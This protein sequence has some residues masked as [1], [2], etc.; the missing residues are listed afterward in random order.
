MK[1]IIA[2]TAK[3]EELRSRSQT[4]IPT[5][6][7]KA[8]EDAGGIPVIVPIIN[9]SANVI[10][11]AQFADGFL[12]S[13]GDD[14]RPEY[15]G[16]EPLLNLEISPDERTDFEIALFREVLRLQKPV[17]GICLGAQL[18][19]V[20]LGG[21]L[22]QDIPTQTQDSLDHRSSHTVSIKDGTLLCGILGRTKDISVISVHHQAIKLFGKDLIISA[23]SAD[24]V[25]EAIEMRD[26][27]FCI[28]VQWH[29]EREP[30]DEYTKRL[31]KIFVEKAAA[32]SF[33]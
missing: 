16:E 25:A 3:T 20:A 24:S 8:I 19:N 17:L 27:P 21:T 13:G 32:C 31:F 9:K 15:Y 12:F 23:V 18:I 7:A 33:S 5:A 29:P 11:I 10:S 30:E 1:P 6:Y 2:I 4:T 28:G 22:Y 26:Y 14:I